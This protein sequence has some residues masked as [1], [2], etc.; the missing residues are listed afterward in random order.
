MFKLYFWKQSR[1]Y[2]S[3]LFF[4]QP[5]NTIHT[6]LL[7]FFSRN[8]YSFSTSGSVEDALL[9]THLFAPW[10]IMSS[11]QMMDKGWASE[12]MTFS[13]I[14]NTSKEGLGIKK[15]SLSSG[16]AKLGWLSLIWSHSLLHA[17][18]KPLYYRK[19][20][21]NT[22]STQREAER[23]KLSFEFWEK[24]NFMSEVLSFLT[25]YSCPIA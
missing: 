12:Q 25:Q 17:Y 24:V 18:D 6:A 14:W 19:K 5:S 9:L 16:F 3:H 2:S 23:M 10:T 21:D 7:P 22:D 13:G 4:N 8:C 1:P 11:Y 15:L 20:W